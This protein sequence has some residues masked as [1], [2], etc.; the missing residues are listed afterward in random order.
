VK[1]RCPEATLV[2]VIGH[3]NVAL[4]S[5]ANGSG[6][7]IEFPELLCDFTRQKINQ[8]EPEESMLRDSLINTLLQRGGDA[9]RK[10]LNRFSGFHLAAEPHAVSQTAKVVDFHLPDSGTALKRGV[11]ESHSGSIFRNWR[12]PRRFLRSFG[13]GFA[14]LCK[15]HQ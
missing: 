9:E 12:K 3:R 1:A 11:N 7:I 15:H 8:T 4:K 13:C 14:A 6:R 5:S 2:L 10:D